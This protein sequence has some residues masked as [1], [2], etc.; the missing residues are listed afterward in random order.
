MPY[1]EWQ[2]QI[3]AL[4]SRLP[5]KLDDGLTALVERTQSRGAEFPARQILKLIT[6]SIAENGNDMLEDVVA[7]LV[8]IATSYQNGLVEHEYDYF[9]SL[10]NEYYDV[11]SLFSGENVREDN[12]ILKLR[13]E[14]KSD[15][16][17]LLVLVCLIHV[18]VPRTI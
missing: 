1:S 7:P 11:E 6:K 5:P 15:L 4:H 8:S 17:K 10:I 13:D 12:V 9:A 3:S 18:L 16:K 2:Q 14:N